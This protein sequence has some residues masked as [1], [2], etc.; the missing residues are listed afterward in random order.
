MR[1][2]ESHT[3]FDLDLAVSQ[4]NENPVFYVQ[5][6]HARISS[7]LKQMDIAEDSQGDPTLLTHPAEINLIRKIADLPDEIDLAAR[8]MAP[9]RMTTYVHDLSGL[10]HSFYNSC[11]CVG[12]SPELSAARA[13]LIR[14]T[15]QTIKN[16]L[17][18]LG[19]TAPE[20]M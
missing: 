16:C 2:A 9:N 19:I 6:A 18:L 14:A 10:F 4:S 8:L 13:D 7:I 15:R 1:G 17:T 3:D 5:Y 20:R 12:Q 11:R